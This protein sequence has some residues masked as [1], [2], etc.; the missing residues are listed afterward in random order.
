MINPVFEEKDKNVRLKG[1]MPVYTVKGNLNQSAMKTMCLSAVNS[2][3]FTSAIPNN[4]IYKYS[5]SELK[6]AYYDIHNPSNDKQLSNASNRIALEEYFKLISAFKIIK[7]DKKSL[8]INKYEVSSK[9]VAEFCSRFSFELTNGQKQA[10]NDV[11][12]DL[13]SI[14]VMN[15]LLQGDVGSGKTAVSR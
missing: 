5:I 6:K 2:L 7:G 15:R 13:T 3:D 4:L 9:Q 14:S 12:K 8:R 1:L 10:I 11:Y